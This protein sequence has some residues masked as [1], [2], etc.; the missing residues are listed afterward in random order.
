MKVTTFAMTPVPPFRLGLTSW[1]LRRRPDNTIDRWDG[2]TYRRVMV[3]A[4]VPVEVSVTQDGPAAAP[5]LSV[6]A[7]AEELPK[8]IE[9]AIAGSLELLLGTRVDLSP[10]YAFAARDARLHELAA[11]FRGF[12]PPRFPSVF[13]ALCNGILCQQVSLA[14]GIQLLN[15]LARGWGEPFKEMGGS[16][17]AFPLPE[18]ISRVRM[19]SLRKL[20]LSTNKARALI[21]C[22]RTCRDGGL[23]RGSLM[24][25]DDEAALA[26]L[27]DLRGVGA[28]TAQYALL[29][30]LGRLHI[31]PLAD[32][33]ALNG[34]RRWLAL[35]T[36]LDPE[37]ARRILSRWQ[38]YAGLIYFHLLLDRL[39]REGRLG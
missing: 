2:T 15:R 30:G 13:E 37:R 28:W 23:E 20:G 39:D 35:R 9:K 16:A 14:L 5:R 21:E 26:A 19:Q 7:Q 31:F 4:G 17:R 38:P 24:Q 25:M 29:R 27:D 8:G 36:K 11:R 33:G 18:R 22:A 10:F 6:Q 32:S 12:K 1:A 3:T 34:L